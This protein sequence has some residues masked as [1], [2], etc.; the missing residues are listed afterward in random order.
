MKIKYL[1]PILV[2]LTA[3]APVPLGSSAA[4]PKKITSLGLYD[5]TVVAPGQTTYVAIT[6]N[7][8]HLNVPDDLFDQEVPIDFENQN[9][10][11]NVKSL[12]MPV[13]WISLKAPELPQGWKIDLARSVLI[14][15]I[16]KTT[17]TG[18]SINVRFYDRV[19]LVYAITAPNTREAKSLKFRIDTPKGGGDDIVLLV[20][21]E[22]Q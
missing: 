17:Q 9:A 6:Y 16:V 7:A 18:S 21:T 11:G 12:E 1:L 20:S 19:K 15:E 22:Q 14:R 5:A 10:I 8:S 13:N 4:N 3:C 2:V